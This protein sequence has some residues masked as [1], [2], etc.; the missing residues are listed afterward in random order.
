MHNCCKHI[1]SPRVR[2]TKKANFSNEIVWNDSNCATGTTSRKIRWFFGVNAQ[3]RYQTEWSDPSQVFPIGSPSTFTTANAQWK[4]VA[5]YLIGLGVNVK[6]GD[7]IYIYT[8]VQ[9]CN[10]KKAVSN[11]I[12]AQVTDIATSLLCNTQFVKSYSNTGTP[13]NGWTA[14]NGVFAFNNGL[15]NTDVGSTWTDI[16]PGDEQMFATLNGS[17]GRVFVT[18][19]GM[20]GLTV[21]KPTGFTNVNAN[22]Y[23]LLLNGQVQYPNRFTEVGT[24][25]VEFDDPLSP[26]DIVQFIQLTP[27]SSCKIQ[28]IVPLSIQNITGNTFALPTTY[29][30]QNTSKWILLRNGKAMYQDNGSQFGFSISGSTVTLIRPAESEDFALI[31]ITI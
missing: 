18:I 17:S 2:L 4:N 3:A 6:E 21:T 19:T 9:N 27:L 22:E 28:T 10:G 11:R 8:Q 26:L 20:T 29:G 31:V 14:Q 1:G 7:Y 13:P 23:I 25:I 30:S 16:Q 15:L 12:I 5:Q 24:T